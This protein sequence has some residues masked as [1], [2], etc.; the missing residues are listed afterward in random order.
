MA[1]VVIRSISQS[2]NIPN[3]RIFPILETRS[4]R[5]SFKHNCYFSTLSLLLFKNLDQRTDWIRTGFLTFQKVIF[6]YFSRI[7]LFFYFE[8]LYFILFHFINAK[9]TLYSKHTLLQKIEDMGRIQAREGK[10][11]FHLSPR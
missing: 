8:D 10:L 7:R 2:Q 5:D 11:S 4:P 3:F 9:H 6:N 1:R